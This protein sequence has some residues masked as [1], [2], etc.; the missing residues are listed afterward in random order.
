M[1]RFSFYPIGGSCFGTIGIF[2][3]LLVAILFVS[4]RWI[5]VDSGEDDS[6]ELAF[7]RRVLFWIRFCALL[8]LFLA[9]LRPTIIYTATERLSSSLVLLLDDSESMSRADEING[10]TR[11]KVALDSLLNSRVVLGRIQDYADVK[12]YNFNSGLV[13][14]QIFGG[15]VEGMSSIPKGRETAIGAALDSVR[16]Q[17]IGKRVLG[18]IILTDGSQRT[19]PPRDTLPH[20]AAMRM[21]DAGITL[22]AVRLGNA[23]GSSDF[24]DVAVN[25]MHANDKVFVKNEFHVTGMIR[26]TGYANISIPVQLLFED[27]KGEMKV[28]DEK[29]VQTSSD[30][31]LIPYKLSY[32]PQGTG[33]FKYSINVPTQDKELIDTNNRQSNFVR[34]IDGGLKVLFIQGERHF[35]QAPLKQSLD[36][37]A[38]INVTYLDVRVGKFKVMN[39]EGSFRSRLERVTRERDSWLNT[40]FARGAYNVYILDNLDSIAFK[41]DELQALVDRVREGAGLIMLGGFNA[42]GAGGYAD[43]PLAEV[44]PV[45]MRGVDRQMLDSPIRKDL[46][47]WDKIRML[48][49]GADGRVGSN[50]TAHYI[51]RLVQTTEK[52]EQLWRVLPELQ[53]ANRFDRIKSSATVIAAGENGERLLVSQLFGLGRVLAF[54]GDT[55]YRWRLAGFNEEHKLFWRHVILWL[56]KMDDVFENDCYITMENV[57]LL[58]GDLAKFQI[59]LKS[60]SGEEVK[61]FKSEV[62]VYHPD[63]L[64]RSVV[65]VDDDGVKAGTFRETE[66]AGD[67]KIEVKIDKSSLKEEFQNGVAIARF[68][69]Q[70]QNLE[71]DSPIAY[72]NLLDNI[73]ATSGG[74]SI[75]PEQLNSLLEELL[76][77][78]DEFIESR[79]TSK[80]LYDGWWCLLFFALLLCT[81]WFLRKQWGLV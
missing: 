7:R 80:T 54:A 53:G 57:R 35:D 51:M 65:V 11:Y 78:T 36:E 38:D 10:N 76:K 63:G 8:I 40:A 72:P 44:S 13:P 22:Y 45:E 71:L 33:Y 15:V 18:V 1:I 69:V 21:R 14:F 16:E 61:D 2:L 68:M 37:S 43:T 31:H 24:R 74:R 48:P 4:R 47:Y 73:S 32:A 19:R 17:L 30:D 26:V 6:G 41:K 81:E 64:C 23:G 59:H 20:D 55:T 75:A 28:V 50:L 29:S 67:Y 34:V 70:D 58:P 77:K 49:V 27:E 46:H 56:A 39:R 9:M 42:F 66:Q 3:F 60:S 12:C 62:V 79:E 25:D 5:F 52:N